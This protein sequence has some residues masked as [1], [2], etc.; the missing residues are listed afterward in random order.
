M[1]IDRYIATNQPTWDRLGVLTAR[2]GRSVR[3]LSPAELDEL[4]RLYQRVS[5]HLSY[6]RTYYRD[7]SLTAT[8]TR[9]VA[10]AGAVVYG[11][12]S[13]SLRSVGR[14]FAVTFPAAV[15]HARRYVL[16]SFALTVVPAFGMGVWLAHSPAALDAS[17]PAAVRE[18]YVNEAFEDYYS[19]QPAE[20]FAAKVFTNNVQVGFLAFAGGVLACVPTAY[21]LAFNGAR[22][23]EV[24]GLFASVGQS[25]KFWGLILPHGLLELTGVFIAGA[26]GLMLGWSLID[27]GDRPRGTALVEE[28]RRAIVVVLGLI[29]VFATAGFIEG[30]ITGHVGSTAVRVGIGATAEAAF[31]LY[32]VTRGRAAAR[33]GITGALGEDEGSGWAAQPPT[34]SAN[35]AS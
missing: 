5:T 28:G 24:A 8:L 32:V 35:M 1:D 26:T 6:A 25:A 4:V 13:R 10:R 33:R 21:V 18:A 3:R 11:T 14:F 17:A 7:P 9:L 31:I 19:S 27:P 20:A 30:F 15:W 34:L 12:R 16:V 29:A 23:G 22:L 2:A